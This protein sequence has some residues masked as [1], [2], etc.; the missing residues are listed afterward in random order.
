MFNSRKRLGTHLKQI[1]SLA[2]LS[3]YSVSVGTGIDRSRLS[4]IE[5]GYVCARADEIQQIERFVADAEY[6][7]A[8]RLKRVLLVS[9]PAANKCGPVS[10][11][12]Q[13]AKP[14]GP[15]RKGP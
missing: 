8:A 11:G 12:M 6:Q 10:A 4:S 14:E 1:R 13:L 7:R 15:D 9:Q 5:N 2:G 3:Q